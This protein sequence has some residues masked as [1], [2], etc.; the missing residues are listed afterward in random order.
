MNK[1][2]FYIPDDIKDDWKDAIKEFLDFIMTS[3]ENEVIIYRNQYIN[4]LSEIQYK[5]L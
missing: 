5:I 4:E 3:E 1:F 2:E